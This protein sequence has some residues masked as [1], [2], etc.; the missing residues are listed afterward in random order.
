MTQMPDTGAPLAASVTVPDTT[1]PGNNA[2]SATRNGD[3]LPTVTGVAWAE[4]DA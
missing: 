4:L 3:S 1:A 2:A